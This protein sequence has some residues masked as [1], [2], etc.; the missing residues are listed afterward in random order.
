MN[1]PLK[2][3]SLFVLMAVGLPCPGM[4]Q[5][6]G[7]APNDTV[8]SRPRPEVAPLGIHMGG[9]FLFPKVALS[10][11][12][13]DNI[14]R[15][16]SGT[17]DDFITALSPSVQLKSNW[18]RHAL[19]FGASAHI[20]RYASHSSENYNDYNA[21]ANGRLDISGDSNLSGS[22]SYSKLHEERGSPDG[23]NGINPT[24]YKVGTANASFLHRFN[25]V[26]V[27]VAGQVQNY[28]YNNVTLAGGAVSNQKVRDRNDYEGSVK[29]AYEFVPEYEAYLKAAYNTR[30]YISAIDS[31]GINRDSHGYQTDAG[32]RINL[33]G[34]TFGDVFVGYRSQDY[35]DP[36]L[37]T[38]SG[39]DYGASLTWNATTLT[40]AK[41]GVTRTI[42]ESTLSGASGYL[43]TVYRVSI[44]HELLRN[45][46]VGGNV[47]YADNDYQG[48]NRHDK[49]V[50][51]GAYARFLM[52]RYL[53]LSAGYD[54]TNRNSN[55]ANG[56]YT[57]NSFLIK[58]EGQL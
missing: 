57:D 15:T 32:I 7:S 37:K 50:G 48:I 8:L 28:S 44:D 31:G 23:A 47:S 34:K 26:S 27:T 42:R 36:S 5:D 54:F 16:D 38:I 45:L 52:N 53:Y 4:A 9:F 49:Y 22:V 51:A 6:Q 33:T 58:V 41:L 29:L 30:N 19:N 2:L 24:I 17:S 18:G 13:D 43:D 35:K 14:Y 46:L 11:I 40:T 25:R 3:G 56:D 39:L 12:Y 55:I 21:F 10:E 1:G 20:G